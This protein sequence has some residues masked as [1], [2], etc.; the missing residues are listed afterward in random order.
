MTNLGYYDFEIK[1]RQQ[2]ID[3]L[4]EKIR[5]TDDPE[6]QSHWTR[7]LCILISG[8]LETSLRTIYAGYASNKAAPTVSN[9]VGSQLEYFQNPNMQKILELAGAFSPKWQAELNCLDDRV[10]EAVNSIVNNRNSIS[11]GSDVGISY[12]RLKD[13]YNGALELIDKIQSLCA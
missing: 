10:K 2:R 1:R 8:F 3:R 9:Y 13:Y 6:M 12:G 5:I 4:F 11:H 7:Y